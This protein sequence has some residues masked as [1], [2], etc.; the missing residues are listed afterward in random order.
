MLRLID[1]RNPR[2]PDRLWFTD[3]EHDL[4]V[5]FDPQKRPVGFQFS[6]NKNS[7]EH[8]IQW[9]AE[10][11]FSHDKIDDGENYDGSY[12]MTPIMVPDGSFDNRKIADHF[13][14]ISDNLEPGLVEFIYQV[15]L[16]YDQ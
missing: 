14:S 6:Y 4:F 10:N 5:W 15:L 9:T 11:G 1:T 12:K 3:H 16:S 7:D 8:A 2:H 13:K